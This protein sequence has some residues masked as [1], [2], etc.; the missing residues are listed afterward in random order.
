MYLKKGR[1]RGGTKTKNIPL[2]S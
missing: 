2:R 1:G